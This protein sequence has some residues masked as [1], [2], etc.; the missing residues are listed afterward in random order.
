MDKQRERFEA[1]W[2]NTRPVSGQ[3]QYCKAAWQAAEA[4]TIERLNVR[5]PVAWIIDGEIVESED[6]DYPTLEL[7]RRGYIPLFTKATLEDLK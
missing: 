3:K 2:L 5:E 4:T 7:E 1:W 6:G